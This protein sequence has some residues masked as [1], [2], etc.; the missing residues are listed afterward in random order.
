MFEIY[1]PID[2]VLEPQISLAPQQQSLQQQQA[3][4]AQ[5]RAEETAAKEAAN[6]VVQDAAVDSSKAADL[7]DVSAE[8]HSATKKDAIAADTVRAESPHDESDYEDNITVTVPP[9]HLQSGDAFRDRHLNGGGVGGGGYPH[10]HLMPPGMDTPPTGIISH[11]QRLQ[12]GFETNL[13]II[14]FF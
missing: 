8:E 14:F 5:K 2:Y 11:A 9:A 4:V 3:A 6:A 7:S 10:R 1:L 12:V 13:I